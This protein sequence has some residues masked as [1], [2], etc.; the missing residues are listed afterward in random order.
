MEMKLEEKD[1]KDW[2]YK[3]EG[4]VNLVLSY[5]GSSP[6]FM[7]KVIRV[8]KVPRNESKNEVQ[9]LFLSK[10]ELTLWE[11]AGE[12]I[13]SPTKEI[14][15]QLFVKCVMAPLLGPEF[16]DPGTCVLVSREFLES[17][18]RDVLSE[19]PLWR[20]DA[21][22]VNIC[23]DSVLLMSDHSVFPN[24]STKGE[25]CISVEIK[26]KCGFLPSSTCIADK[27]AFKKNVSRFKMHQHLKHKDLKVSQ[28]S[29]YE[30]LDLFSGSRE[31]ID[32]AIK[33]LFSTPQNNLRVFLDG[34]LIY[35]ELG[36][37]ADGTNFSAE[38]FEDHIRS[39][40]RSE[41]GSSTTSFVNLVG[42]AIIKLGVL[43]RLLEIQKL[44]KYDIEGTIHAY[45]DI[46]S[47]P[48]KLCGYT[49]GEKQTRK[50][51]SL[52]SLPFDESLK[53]VKDYLIAATAK[54]CSLMISFCPREE[55]DPDSPYKTVYLDAT[56]QWFEC[57]ACFID[58]DLK[59]LKKMEFYYELDQKIVNY[60][61]QMVKPGLGVANGGGIEGHETGY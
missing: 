39:F 43:E 38:S 13:R 40:I 17:V 20:V 41:S 37:G 19:R 23:A 45:Y 60:Y 4:A 6:E 26:P 31:R 7:G 55:V 59:P 34:A 8:Q 32:K 22:K 24:S 52:H 56:N 28:L 54:D 27:N 50:H 36:G 14:G 2:K 15:E 29:E 21:A 25:S 58:L 61:R 1:A 49:S 18:E 51:S 12:F 35:G 3:G 5:I 11:D 57:E 48:C 33:A 42:Q 10:H 9:G 44:D 47:E 30:P 53:I 16:V 46:V